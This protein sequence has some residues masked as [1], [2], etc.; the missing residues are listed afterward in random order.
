MAPPVALVFVAVPK[1]CGIE[2]EYG[3]VL[4]GTGE[5]NPVLAYVLDQHPKLFAATK[6]SMTGVGVL[7]LVA[8]ARAR[9]FNVMRVGTLL[10]IVLVG[11]ATL[12]LYEWWLLRA[13]L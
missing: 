8:I 7:V 9:I 12:I 4:R 3:V 5:A 11:Y 6:M 10:H 1:V 2:T 13:I